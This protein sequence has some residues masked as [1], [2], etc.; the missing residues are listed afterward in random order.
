MSLYYL[1]PSTVYTI[2]SSGPVLVFLVDYLRNGAKVTG[3]QLSGIIIGFMSILITI[4]SNLIM[5]MLGYTFESPS[6]FHY[7]QTSLTVVSFVSLALFLVQFSVAYGI[8]LTKEIHTQDAFQIGF[9]FGFSQVIFSAIL[10]FF[11][12]QSSISFA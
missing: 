3:K 7:I 6:E 9:H 4:N 12:D 11:F 5:K 1:S 8:I 2:N 10:N